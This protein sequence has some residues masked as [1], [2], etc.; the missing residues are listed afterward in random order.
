MANKYADRLRK[1]IW[2]R[3]EL[4]TTISTRKLDKILEDMEKEDES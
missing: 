4:T 2:G 1:A 3:G